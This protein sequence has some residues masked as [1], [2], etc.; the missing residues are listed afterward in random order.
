MGFFMN[1]ILDQTRACLDQKIRTENKPTGYAR[2]QRVGFWEGE[3]VLETA[4]EIF[5]RAEFDGFRRFDLDA[6]ARL[7]I[8]AHA[9]FAI[10]H[11]ERA[12]ADELHGLAFFEVG[13]DPVDH[14]V[15]GAFGIRLAAFE[16]FLDGL[17]EFDFVHVF[18]LLRLAAR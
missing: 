10:H 14:G 6:F 11:A 16:V 4:F 5:A 1:A 3:I 2:A 17:D 7:R 18:A 12:E 9:R 8:H 15:D 13:F